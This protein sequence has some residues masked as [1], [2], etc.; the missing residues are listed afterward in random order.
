MN[1]HQIQREPWHIRWYNY[2]KYSIP[3]IFTVLGTLVFTLF[4]DFRTGDVNFLSHISAIN[5]LTNKIIG[6]YLFS[7]YMISLVQLANSIAFSKKRSPVSLVTFTILN[8]LQVYLV[9]LYVNV[10]YTEVA[11]RT[12]GFFIPEFG[13][14]SINIMITGAIL[15][16]IATIFAWFYVDWKYVKIEE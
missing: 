10:F 3:V 2:N 14:F 15:Y 5:V 7:I 4:L 11:V 12:D 6:F 13:Y 16:V 9:Y 1:D 8:A